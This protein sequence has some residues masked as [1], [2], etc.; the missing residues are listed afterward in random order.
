[1]VLIFAQYDKILFFLIYEIINMNNE[2]LLKLVNGYLFYAFWRNIFS[3]GLIPANPVIQSLYIHLKTLP[4][5]RLKDE[6][7]AGP[8]YN[9]LTSINKNIID[10]NSTRSSWGI[11]SI[12]RMALNFE[13]IKS[14][15]LADNQKAKLIIVQLKTD[16]ESLQSEYQDSI[17]KLQVDCKT[18]AEKQLALLKRAEAAEDEVSSLRVKLDEQLST[19][20]NLQLE[21]SEARKLGLHESSSLQEPYE[22][23][24]FFARSLYSPASSAQVLEDDA[25]SNDYSEDSPWSPNAIL[26]A[27]SAMLHA[28]AEPA[29]KAV[30]G[31][32]VRRSNQTF[33]GSTHEER[34]QIQTLYNISPRL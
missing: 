5:E 11:L 29:A 26:Q 18:A 25:A 3:F 31:E 1:M 28:A 33:F 30:S 2:Q 21:L 9:Q 16:A 14:T 32:L 34:P 10:V 4:T 19:I 22:D 12:I 8:F 20:S 17:S 13:N 15:L 24:L 7:I 23:H 27:E 6:F